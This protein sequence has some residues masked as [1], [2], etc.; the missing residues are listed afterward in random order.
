MQL[1]KLLRAGVAG[2]L[3]TLSDL[4]TLTVLVGI[5]HVDARVASIPALIV[6]GVVNFVGNRYFA[7]R[8]ANGHLGRQA[9]GYTVVELVALALNALLYDLALRLVPGLRPFY[10]LVRLVASHLVFLG[11]SYPL[12]QRVFRV[13]MTAR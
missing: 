8:A 10:W 11:F 2:G 9:A 7:F 5:F 3:A 13:D 4:A 1:F 12:W 6:G